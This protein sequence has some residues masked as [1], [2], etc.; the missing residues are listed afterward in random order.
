VIV[1]TLDTVRSQIAQTPNIQAALAYLRKLDPESVQD[2]RYPVLGEAVF[3]II[4]SYQ[5]QSLAD[6]VEIEGHRKYIDIYRMLAGRERV[7]WT[8]L[9]KL[10]GLP[11]YDSQKDVWT[12]TVDASALSYLT[13]EPGDA[14][15]LY[16]EDAHGAQFAV[17]APASARKV[18]MK[19]AVD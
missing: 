14:A 9:S 7:G 2:G 17:N 6:A 5:T 12:K 1:G 8:P 11:D 19:V 10:A 15:V 18:V 16:P 13:L 4:Q 3:A